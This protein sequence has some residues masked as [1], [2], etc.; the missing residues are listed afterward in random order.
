MIAQ[1]DKD[2]I[3]MRP[4][5]VPRRLVSYALFEGRPL[6]TRG[7]WIN[8]LLFALFRLVKRFPPLKR[9]QKPV[10]ILGTGRS[11]TTI[12]GVLFHMHR[13]CG[14]LN[15][16]KAMWHAIYPHEDLV[17]SYSRGE[18][19]Y[20][21]EEADATPE[22][23][24]TARRL[25][26]FYLFQ[27]GARRVVDKY[28]EMIFRIPFLRAI[29]PDARLVFLA[30]NGLDTL[31]SIASWSG[32]HTSQ[33]ET[34]THDWWGVDNRK[35]KLMVEQVAAQDKLLSPHIEVISTFTRHEDMAAVEWILTMREGLRW[36][37]S[38]SGAVHLVRYEELVRDPDGSLSRL[39]D[40][41]E[42]PRDEVMLG[43]ARKVLSPPPPKRP[44]TLHPAILSAFDETMSAMGYPTE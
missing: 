22:V 24:E 16:P 42:L 23:M 8:P 43:Y 26:G 13:Q 10:Y 33:V 19:R 35:W 7:Q 32:T 28:P 41:C 14:F 27:T 25:F 40:F 12:L 17:G 34:E 4:F 44:V 37:E 5:L 9:V 11:G 18:V 3:K 21:L 2:I 6:T 30:R 38:L 31:R 20:R 15:E 29:F 39:L 1:L 36:M